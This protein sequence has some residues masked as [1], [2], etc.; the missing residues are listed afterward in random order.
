MNEGTAAARRA[1][2]SPAGP[3][4]RRPAITGDI[5]IYLA[6]G[7]AAG[8]FVSGLAGFGMALFA[9]GFF[10]SVLSPEQAVAIAVVLSVFGG[11]QGTWEVRRAVRDNPRRLARFLL[12]AV[13]GIP[14]GVMTLQLIEAQTL[15]VMIGVFLI[16]YGGYFSLRR[17]LPNLTQPTPAIDVGVGF[18]GGVLGGAAGLSGALPTMWCAM[19][20]WPKAETR[21]VLQPYNTVVLLLT[22][23]LLAAKGAYTPQVLLGIVVALPVSLSFF[24]LGLMVFRRLPDP[25]F[26]RLLISMSFVAGAMLLIRELF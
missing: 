16:L 2:H 19:R 25:V 14:L 8:G 5:A 4:F 20:T 7:A 3:Q 13:I 22:A 6:L 1:A 9:L 18:T 11:F 24:Q 15:K 10:L 12:P 23:L 26:R 17:A 21:A